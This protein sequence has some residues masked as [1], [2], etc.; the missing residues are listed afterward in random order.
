MKRT[1]IISA[2]IGTA[3][4][5][6]AFMV[7]AGQPDPTDH[8]S[9]TKLQQ[10]A[11]AEHQNRM[12]EWSAGLGVDLPGAPALAGTARSVPA[13]VA[14]EAAQPSRATYQDMQQLQLAKETAYQG[15]MREWA[16]GLGIDLSGSAIAAQPSISNALIADR[17]RD[18]RTQGY[19]PEADEEH[20]R[21]A[22][23]DDDEDHEHSRKA[24]HDDSDDDEEHT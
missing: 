11:Q 9:A 13:D 19:R 3:A 17:G 4:L 12:R 23:H 7:M 24:E 10:S 6:P 1:Y 20:A 16:T 2:I 5:V 15:R 14:A 22:A 21:A 8:R 18:G